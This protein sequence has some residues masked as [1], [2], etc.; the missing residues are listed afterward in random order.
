M[1]APYIIS[2]G[3]AIIPI[4]AKENPMDSGFLLYISIDDGDS[5]SL[6]G[7]SLN[8]QPYGTLEYNYGVTYTIDK[9][10][11]LTID[12]ESGADEIETTTW[13]NVYAGN[14]NTAIL[15]DEIITFKDITPVSGT[16]Y[17]LEN[18]VRGRYG[19]VKKAHTA[20]EDFYFIHP[21]IETFSNTEIIAG[22]VSVNAPGVDGSR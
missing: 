16:L 17:L 2:E 9:T 15:G 11:G 19:T 1:E 21:G 8:I 12:F 4:A 6:L 13:S 3:T 20:G 18:V 10:E 7:S 14:F 5:Y 22:L